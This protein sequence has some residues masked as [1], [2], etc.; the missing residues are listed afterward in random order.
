MGY[1]FKDDFPMS[2]TNKSVPNSLQNALVINFVRWHLLGG[3]VYN[4]KAQTRPSKAWRGQTSMPLKVWAHFGTLRIQHIPNIYMIISHRNKNTHH[5]SHLGFTPHTH[6]HTHF[7]IC[8][9]T[10]FVADGSPTSC[11][12]FQCDSFLHD[13]LWNSPL[14]KNIWKANNSIHKQH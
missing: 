9:K 13:L 5:F 11:A 4:L 1:I 7:T 3:W 8:K 10:V 6:R 12:L 14:L 2:F